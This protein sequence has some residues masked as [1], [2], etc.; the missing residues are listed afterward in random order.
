MYRQLFLRCGR[1]GDGLGAHLRGVRCVRPRLRVR[2]FRPVNPPYGVRGSNHYGMHLRGYVGDDD[3]RAARHDDDHA[4][5]VY[6]DHARAGLRVYGAL[7]V[8][9]GRRVRYVGVPLG[10][11]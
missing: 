9:V 6:H 1:C 5:A 10:Q 11:L 2:V 3:D 4:R 8:G 7:S